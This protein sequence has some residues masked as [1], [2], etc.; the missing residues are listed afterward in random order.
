MATIL[1]VA[2]VTPRVLQNRKL[3]YPVFRRV[4]IQRFSGTRSPDSV[5]WTAGTDKYWRDQLAMYNGGV[6][7]DRIHPTTLKVIKFCNHFPMGH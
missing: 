5:M 4:L 7:D 6:R 2:K 1:H 3:R